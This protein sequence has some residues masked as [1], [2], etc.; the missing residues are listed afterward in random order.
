MKALWISL[1]ATWSMLS[2]ALGQN[3]DPLTVDPKF[4]AE[5]R[6]LTAHDARRNRDIPVRVYLPAN[7]QSAPVVL[8]SHGL[9][10]S[11][12][13][14]KFL[15]EHWAARGYVVVFL[16]H[17]G[18]D[19]AVWREVAPKERL[20]ALR[21]AAS[22][23]NFLL[24]VKDVPAVLDQLETWNA[25]GPLAGRM[26]LTQVGMSGHSFGA[27]TTEAVSGETF[28]ATGNKLNDSRIRAAVVLSPSTP[29]ATSAE[30]A[31]GNVTIAWLLMTGTND[32]TFIGDADMQ[33]RLGVYP[34]L[35]GAPKYQVVL[36]KAEHSAFTD[37]ALPGDRE[38]RNP[39]HH[40][41]IVALSTAFWDAFLRGD[42]NALAWLN[43]AGPRT[44]LEAADDWKASP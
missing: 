33:S 38:T 18:S 20:E 21:E 2:G 43:G 31:F 30:K 26:D 25:S 17:A 3:Y 1:V 44:V 29:K 6:E 19:D 5:T 41:A 36:N 12:A 27:V 32:V 24:R 10:G 42:K 8:F 34:A 4:Q 16:Q 9:G 13:G 22:L 7:K 28:P 15:G 37:R 39:N 14:G 23:E 35:H 40:R 11:R